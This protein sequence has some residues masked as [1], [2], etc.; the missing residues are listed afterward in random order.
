M[1]IDEQIKGARRELDFRRRLYPNWVA[2]G[3]ITQKEA[4]YQIEV[5]EQIICTLEGVK[6]FVVS[7]F[8]RDRTLLEQAKTETCPQD[9][10]F[11]ID[12]KA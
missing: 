7:T 8:A 12:N 9:S 4:Q 2:N 1:T 5:M 6:S 3:K 10:L 11:N